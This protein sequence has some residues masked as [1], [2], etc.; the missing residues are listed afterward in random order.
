M[1]KSLNYKFHQLKFRNLINIS[2]IIVIGVIGTF[3]IL[4]IAKAQTFDVFDEAAHFDYVD[5][6]QNGSPPIT[7]EFLGQKT[8]LMIDCTGSWPSIPKNCSEINRN[9]ANYPAQGFS[10][11]SQQPPLAY[12]PFIALNASNILDQQQL[13]DYRLGNIFWYVLCIFLLAFYVIR[14]KLNSVQTILLSIPILLSPIALHAFGTINNDA[15]GLVSGLLFLAFPLFKITN[16]KMELL[17]LI[18]FGV[19]LG[20]AKAIFLFIPASMILALLILELTRK[21]SPKVNPFEILKRKV[22]EVKFEPMKPEIFW[23]M[24]KLFI[25]IS[26]GFISTLV[27]FIIQEY[28][29]IVP[30]SKVLF[31]LQGFALTDHIQVRTITSGVLANLQLFGSYIPSN[32]AQIA[33]LAVVG[34]L[35]LAINSSLYVNRFYGLTFLVGV[36]SLAIFWVIF[37]FYA[38]HFNFASQTRYMIVFIPIISFCIPYLPRILSFSLII[39]ILS[40]ALFAL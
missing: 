35:V 34:I 9:P 22:L 5:K 19:F 3:N 23:T 32:L 37:N 26:S 2:I 10:Y 6:L 13:F 7:G 27:Y 33:T 30:A 25:V 11:E 16:K 4:N 28:R 31:A 15:I 17:F 36:V 1:H 18:L 40:L 12:L 21:N 8:L 20:L 24:K 38:G 29:S 14:N 39:P